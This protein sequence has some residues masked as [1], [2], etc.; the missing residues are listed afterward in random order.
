MDKLSGYLSKLFC[1]P[2]ENGS[3]RKGKNLPPVFQKGL[4]VQK[5]KKK[6]K[7]KKQEF[8]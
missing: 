6:K 5:K 4:G 2:S 7:K 8:T 1:L 3:V